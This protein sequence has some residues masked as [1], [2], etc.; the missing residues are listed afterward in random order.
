MAIQRW[1]EDGLTGEIGK[2]SPIE[3]GAGRPVQNDQLTALFHTREAAGQVGDRRP[4][5]EKGTEKMPR[6]PR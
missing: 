1:L 3:L 2:N 5:A 6:F 4:G